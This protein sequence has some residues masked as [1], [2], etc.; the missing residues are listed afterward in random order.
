MLVYPKVEIRW[1]PSGALV[2]DTFITLNNDC[3]AD[4]DVQLFIVCETGAHIDNTFTVTENQPLYWSA[5]TG[6]PLSLSPWTVLGDAYPDP[7]GSGDLIMRGFAL[8]WAIN[9]EYEEIRWNH[10]YG[11]ATIVDYRGGSG[12][13]YSAYS[14][15]VVD[16]FIQNGQQ[17]GSPGELY[18]DGDEYATGFDKLLL[19][20]FASGSWALSTA[21]FGATVDTDLTLLILHNDLR[22]EGEGGRTT[23]VVFSVWNE[24]ETLFSGMEYCI[25]GWDETL[26]SLLGGHFLRQNLHTDKGRAR[27]DGKGSVVCPG[28][29][30][31]SLL[32]VAAKMLA[33]DGGDLTGTSGAML[34]GAGEQDATIFFDVQELAPEKADCEDRDEKGSSATTRQGRL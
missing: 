33:F 13:E 12:W 2:Q 7:E 9:M 20:F 8:V 28:S 3:N 6:D 16:P 34:A 11:G 22:Q 4:V 23:K 27:I 19:D 10:L 14:F 17:S 21:A 5:C 1:S 25:D 24:N 15:P 18:L 32:G 30:D 31:E 29:T 26:L